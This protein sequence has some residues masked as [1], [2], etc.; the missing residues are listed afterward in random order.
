[1][2]PSARAARFRGRVDERSVGADFHPNRADFPP[3]RH[4]A[5]HLPRHVRKHRIGENVIDVSSPAFHLGATRRHGVDQLLRVVQL[6]P[7]VFHHAAAYLIEFQGHDPLQ[8]FVPDRV[9]RNNDHTAQ[10]RRLENLV[11][12][13]LDGCHQRGRLRHGLGIGAQ[14]GQLIGAGVGGQQ[15]DGILE[16][17]LAALS[18]LHDALVEDLVEQLQ[19]IRMRLLHL[20]QEN[21]RVGT[22]ANRFR[23]DAAFPVTDIARRRALESRNGVGFL[24]LGHVNRNEVA[25]ASIQE[26]GQRQRGLRLAH[27]AGTHQ[28]ENAHGF[29]GIV[30]ARP[31]SAR[32]FVQCV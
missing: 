14:L 3:F 15:D 5:E 21:H 6:E 16:I 32:S 26:V 2:P 12:L 20:I 25:F 28:H 13:R 30:E 31:G 27:A 18:I 24:K 23:Q 29:A 8:V 9:V 1:M 10:K 11:E 4:R 22:A 7:V 17:D 19:H